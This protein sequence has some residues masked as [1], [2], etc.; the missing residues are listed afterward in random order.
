MPTKR[1]IYVVKR[2]VIFNGSTSEVE[3]LTEEE[4]NN[5]RERYPN[6]DIPGRTI[7]ISDKEMFISIK[8]TIP[9]EEKVGSYLHD[10]I[11]R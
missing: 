3:D 9:G 6:A 7:S 11:R 4:I 8:I 10:V 5:I 1:L 2:E